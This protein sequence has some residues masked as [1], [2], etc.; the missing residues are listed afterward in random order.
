MLPLKFKA[1]GEK[2]MMKSNMEVAD[3]L[4]EMEQ[5]IDSFEKHKLEDTKSIL[6]DFVL[7]NQKYHAKALELFTSAYQDISEID[8]KK[9][10]QV[11]L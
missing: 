1:G 7:I 10:L 9:D 5:T 8:E 3:A 2:E 4:K 6:T 11:K